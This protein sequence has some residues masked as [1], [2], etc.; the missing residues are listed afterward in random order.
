MDT[1]KQQYKLGDEVTDLDCRLSNYKC[2]MNRIFVHFEE[3]I[4][5]Y[6]NIKGC[7]QRCVCV[8]GYEKRADDCI[9]NIKN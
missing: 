8:A 1:K 9:L 4:T 3:Y 5:E 2:G 7:I 6:S